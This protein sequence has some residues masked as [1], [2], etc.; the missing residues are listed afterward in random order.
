MMTQQGG[1]LDIAKEVPPGY[2]T[3]FILTLKTE[4]NVARSSSL[5]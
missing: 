5:H 1:M 3:A 2:S 4:T